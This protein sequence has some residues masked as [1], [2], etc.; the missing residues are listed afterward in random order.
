MSLLMLGTNYLTGTKRR[1]KPSHVRV[2]RDEVGGS[3]LMTDSTL[4]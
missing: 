2:T 4:R 1:N 3:E